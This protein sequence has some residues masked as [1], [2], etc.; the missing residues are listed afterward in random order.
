MRLYSLL[1]LAV[2]SLV[3]LIGLLVGMQKQ[4]GSG[5]SGKL[6]LYAAA[7][8]KM[9]VDEIVDAY[10]TYH[11]ETLG[12]RMR[13]EVHYAGSG[14]LLARLGTGVE[15]DLYLAADESYV[16]AAREKGLVAEAIPL[17]TMVPVVAFSEDTEGEG[18]DSLAEL[19][20]L[21]RNDLRLGLGE[22][23][24]A[25]IGKISREALEAAGVWEEVSENLAVTKPTV[26]DLGM[27]LQIG[28]LDAAI[29]WDTLA[30]QFELG[31]R[32]LPELSERSMNV[33][34]GVAA[35]S[36]QP[37]AALHLARFMASPEHGAEAFARHHFTAVPGDS[38]ADRP[39][40]ILFSGAINRNAL[41]PLVESFERR[42]GVRVN[43][44]FNGCGLLT[45]QMK[46]MGDQTRASGFPD[47]YVACD[48]Y[49]M[50][51]VEEWFEE[52]VA[53]SGTDLVI[54]TAKGNPHEIESL[55]D[56]ARPGLRLVFGNPTHCTVGALTERLLQHENLHEAVSPNIVER[57]TSSA[58]LVPAVVTGAADAT[59][60][61]ETDT[62]A[63]RDKL[64]VV[65]VNSPRAR[66]VQPFG[67]SRQT[68][69]P[70][71]SKRFYEHIARG[72]EDYEGLGFEW[73]IGKDL[74]QF[75]VTPPSGA[76]EN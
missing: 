34:V 59:L 27:D 16:D 24:S 39:E 33:T 22:P 11:E 13:V 63:E 64:E 60:A 65:P 57:T 10:E 76:R 70:Q 30:R 61:Y 43:A 29:V 26:N 67:R 45:S 54:V 49:Y 36:R 50:D 19:A 8:I 31:F 47:L 5:P 71:L 69:Y 6:V 25:A 41:G 46:V 35:S 58:L 75:S 52:Q 18:V 72:G 4:T 7:G 15:A 55:A 17:A 9:P 62:R 28:A 73:L 32:E 1:A 37:Q 38:W 20:D 48:I 66:A 44:T 21:V 2:V 74:E 68:E 23:G 51:P 3:V 53:V 56:L 12:G 14:D 40:L 42:E